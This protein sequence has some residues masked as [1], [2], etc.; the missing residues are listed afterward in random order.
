MK[1]TSK[2]TGYW[3]MHTDAD[4]TMLDENTIILSKNGKAITVK[5]DVDKA[6][7]YDVSIME[8]AALPSSP[9][10]E[11][12]GSYPNLRKIAI[13]FEGTQADINVR[14]AEVVKT[15]AMPP[16]SEWKAPEG[17]VGGEDEDFS[18]KLYAN[19]Q[20]CINKGK[21]PVIDSGK[22]PEISVVPNDPAKTAR[23]EPL[24]AE[25]DKVKII[26]SD[27]ESK[28][29]RIYVA[30]YTNKGEDV[31]YG[32]YN[33]LPVVNYSVGSLPEPENAGPNMFD[34]DMTTRYTTYTSG[35]E[36]ILDLGERYEVNAIAAAF[37]RG[38]TRTYSF[39]VSFSD[40]GITYVG[41]DSYRS[42]GESEDYE[43]FNVGSKQAR[44]VK[45]TGMGN[46]AN[47]NTNLIELKVLKRK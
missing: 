47:S 44:F 16:I 42:D 20:E 26:V 25:P 17:G 38:S 35:D 13:Y 34:N 14:M 40:D 6:V 39:K 10:L 5:I 19:G 9:K 30:A 1:F 28:Q 8:A 22:L 41:E 33:I 31:I 11:G 15:D 3:F 21:I 27:N 45:F 36:I 4:A 24:E 43:I 32:G 37:W 46:T 29:E 2:S 23:I 7:R 12:D 18:Y